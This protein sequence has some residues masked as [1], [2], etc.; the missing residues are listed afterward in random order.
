MPNA[1]ILFQL[2]Q[3]RELPLVELLRGLRSFHH[4][5][6]PQDREQVVEILGA[7]PEADAVRELLQLYS[8]CQWRT[9]RLQIV[10][11]LGRHSNT[12]S[13]EF[14]MDL[15]T[16]SQDIP[17][18][19]AAI[20]ALGQSAHPLAGRYLNCL[21]AFG[22][23]GLQESVVQ[24]LVALKDFNVCARLEV[25]LTEARLSGNST[26]ASS[27]AQ[28]LALFKW[29][30]S[31]RSVEVEASEIETSEKPGESANPDLTALHKVIDDVFSG[32][33]TPVACGER[34]SG[35]GSKPLLLSSLM[36]FKGESHFRL[37]TQLLTQ[38]R[39]SAIASWYGEIFEL[40][41]CSREQIFQL[42]ESIQW[43]CEAPFLQVLEA[44]RPKALRDIRGPLFEKWFATLSV[45][46]PEAE[47][48]F[49]T[50][51]SSASYTELAS[52]QKI[53]VINHFTHCGMSA[54][55]CKSRLEG[56]VCSLEVFLAHE[57]SD[58]VRARLVR[59]VAQLKVFSAS[60]F[61]F[62]KKNIH[63]PKLTASCLYFVEKC[64]SLE[65][66][67]LL[68]ECL[69]NSAIKNGVPQSLLRALA[70][71]THVPL[72]LPA[73]D[74]FL[75]R[76]LSKEASTETQLLALVLL[77]TV[78]RA[79][80]QAAILGFLK[81]DE[82]LQIAAIVALKSYASELAVEGVAE[83]LKSPSESIVG[84]ALDT[85]TALPGLQAKR[86]VIDFLERNL[87]NL[88][89]CD[90]IIRCLTPSAERTSELAQRLENIAAQNPNHALAK[91][92]AQLCERFRKPTV[93]AS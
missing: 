8:E 66:A 86:M 83:C 54:Q 10:R 64:P 51:M 52:A 16:N 23:E 37:M 47:K 7:I 36:R 13:F 27:L 30:L 59:A 32:Q 42:L 31:A 24:A 44:L 17:L 3:K 5:V 20:T 39:V 19:C 63:D 71:Q 90:K 58:T 67:V 29:P 89:V 48:Y 70:A 2:Y 14:L 60:M 9:T 91:G 1:A 78:P 87:D 74:L 26:R 80:F 56:I 38:L 82:R 62:V 69:G 12:R 33:I 92:F 77:E 79:E 53:I 84:R 73:L 15:A 22:H 49:L 40:N 45:A 35:L 50:F 57:R 81:A 61:D 93:L 34:L 68:D 65:S 21:F 41:S 43:R 46:I 25:L 4:S 55:A 85:L 18:A 76:S 75:R 6:H 28:W 11:A 72:A 88:D